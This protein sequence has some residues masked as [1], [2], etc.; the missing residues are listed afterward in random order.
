MSWVETRHGR[1]RMGQRGITKAALALLIENGDREI[2]VGGGCIALS[3]SRRQPMS[4][5]AAAA[6]RLRNVVAVM[7]G[8]TLVTV[9][10]ATTSEG[11]R[12]RRQQ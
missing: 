6:D 1:K 11:R 2:E 5:P 12:Y 8:D 4:L 7:R 9:L 10:H 3:L